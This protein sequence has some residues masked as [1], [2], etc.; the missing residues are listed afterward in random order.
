MEEIK[1]SAVRI[2]AVSKIYTSGSR[3]CTVLGSI[4]YASRSNTLDLFLGPSGS[5]KTTFLAVSAGLL[6]PDRG[7]VELF[8]NDIGTLS[9][10]ELQQLRAKR[11]SF[12]FQNFLLISSMSLFSNIL[13]AAGIAGVKQPREKVLAAME[14]L[15]IEQLQKL[16]PEEV[17]HG[18][19]QRAVIARALVTGADLIFADEPTAALDR[20]QAESVMKI[21][22]GL[23]EQHNC[24][25]LVASHDPVL[26][27]YADR[28]YNISEGRLTACAKNG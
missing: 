5:G 20:S 23:T 14:E 16:Y 9:R 6:K 24:S 1:S 12:I 25:V 7:S 3:S 27:D 19:K 28:S 18:E 10:K 11:L 4:D 15:R 8:G 21:L 22:K 2:T 26:K 13:L 17:S